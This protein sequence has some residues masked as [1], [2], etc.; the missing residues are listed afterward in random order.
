MVTLASTQKE[1]ALKSG[2]YHQVSI[3][4]QNCTSHSLDCT[5]VVVFHCGTSL[6]GNELLTSG[7]RVLAVSAAAPSLEEAL[8]SVYAAIDRISFEGKAYRRD[9]AHR[10]AG[11]SFSD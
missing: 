1:N 6:N 3:A 9:I 11:Y 5:D 4:T 2:K 7:G 8:F 10:R